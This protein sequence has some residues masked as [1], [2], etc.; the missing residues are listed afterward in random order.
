MIFFVLICRLAP[1]QLLLLL[2]Q[3]IDCCLLRSFFF[4]SSFVPW[5]ETGCNTRPLS[6]L[7]CLVICMQ[8]ALKRG[9]VSRS[10]R[11]SVVFFCKAPIVLSR[12][13]QGG[14]S[15][16]K[17]TMYNAKAAYTDHWTD[18]RS[19][20]PRVHNFKP[21]KLARTNFNQN[22]WFVTS[23]ERLE[24]SKRTFFFFCNDLCFWTWNAFGQ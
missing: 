3:F 2:H 14:V 10:V 12:V 8:T 9:Y 21:S 17:Y 6:R 18:N 23:L 7:D 11:W 20:E 16:T 13:R 19:L 15:S 24:H 1:T 22:I 4:L 5:H